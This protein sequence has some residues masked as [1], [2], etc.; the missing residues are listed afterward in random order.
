[1]IKCDKGDVSFDGTQNQIL[2]ELATLVHALHYD[3]FVERHELTADVSRKLILEAVEAGFQ[4]EEQAERNAVKLTK[5]LLE[6]VISGLERIL[7]G[8]DD[9]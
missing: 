1:M 2:S 7:S 6:K 4:T 3:V 8:K 5:E 9:E